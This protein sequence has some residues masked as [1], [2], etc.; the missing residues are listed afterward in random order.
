VIQY[1]CE[2]CL[3]ELEVESSLSGKPASCNK[4]GHQ[5][6]VPLPEWLPR[7][8][9]PYC[10]EHDWNDLTEEQAGTMVK[11]PKCQHMVRVPGAGKGCSVTACL[12][13][14]VGAWLLSWGLLR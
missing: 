1:K 6:T 12:L 13:V 3:A 5:M 4:C 10:E 8:Q 2:A 11:C 7:L 14:A 9:C